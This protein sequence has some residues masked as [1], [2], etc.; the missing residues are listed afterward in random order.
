VV[1]GTIITSVTDIKSG[2]VNNTLTPD[3][4]VKISGAKLKIAGNDPDAG[5]FFI[6]TGGAGAAIKVDPTDIVINDPGEIIAVVPPALIADTYL[7][8]IVTPYSGGALLKKPHTVTFDKEF[9][10]L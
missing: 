7:V 10:V 9:T 3:Y 1:T 6:S 2:S 4:N 5:L 8:R